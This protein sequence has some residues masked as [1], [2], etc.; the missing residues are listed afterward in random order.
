M[1]MAGKNLHLINNVV[2][3]TD[4]VLFTF[5]SIL[6]PLLEKDLSEK[7]TNYFALRMKKAIVSYDHT[8]PSSMQKNYLEALDH[9]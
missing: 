5:G 4:F 1:A 3:T 2:I 9:V 6:L 7:L 8:C